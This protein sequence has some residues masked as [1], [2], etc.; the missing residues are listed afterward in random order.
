MRD[1]EAQTLLAFVQRRLQ[2]DQAPLLPLEDG[3]R[4][5]ARCDGQNG[6]RERKKGRHESRGV[7]PGAGPER[8]QHAAEQR[9]DQGEREQSPQRAPGRGPVDESGAPAKL[10][11]GAK[12]A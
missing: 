1:E 11:R 7:E 3:D 2:L 6:G 9:R 5:D 8:D 10:G 12:D 4:E